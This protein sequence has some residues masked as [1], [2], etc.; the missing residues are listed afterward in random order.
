MPLPLNTE[1]TIG[2]VSVVVKSTPEKASGNNSRSNDRAPS[3]A[4]LAV[5]SYSG[6]S[7][8]SNLSNGRKGRKL[9]D[10]SGLD[11]ALGVLGAAIALSDGI[12]G[13]WSAGQS[14]FQRAPT[15]TNVKSIQENARKAAATAPSEQL[16]PSR[17]NV[18]DYRV[19]I[20]T[21]FDVFGTDNSYFSLL[22]NTDGVVFPYTP[23]ISVTYKANYTASEGIVHSNFPFQSYKNSQVED[24]TIQAD[25]TVQNN[26][27]GLYWLAVMN[28]FRSATKMFYGASTPQGF[29]PV[30]CTLSGYGTMILPEVPVI[31][32]SFQ[33]DFKDSVQYIEV[34]ALDGSTQFVP[35]VSTVTV[36][37][38]PMYNRELTRKF[39]LNKFAK[40]GLL[41][42]L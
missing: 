20:N 14:I 18:K 25:F 4:D 39:D 31:I 5:S 33:T 32:K 2:G 38:S 28:F 40:G 6:P 29:P 16:Q 26:Q 9:P 15:L 30:V 36:T 21:N 17:R 13:L 10:F 37:V 24:I 11:K 35:T 7:G 8:S 12:K 22:Q 3:G 19:R 27:E 23:T 34:A 1:T 41:G 42:Y